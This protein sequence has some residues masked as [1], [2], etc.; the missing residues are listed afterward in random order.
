MSVTGVQWIMM[1]D[2]LNSA[3]MAPYCFLFSFP[4]SFMDCPGGQSKMLCCL[5]PALSAVCISVGR[6]IGPV[7]V[8][9]TTEFPNTTLQPGSLNGA[10]R[11]QDVLLCHV[12]DACR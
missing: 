10:R 4:V 3:D 9:F 1:S 12:A 8:F 7:Q 2:L 6:K 5:R 11:I